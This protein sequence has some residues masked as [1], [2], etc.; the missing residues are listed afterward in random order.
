MSGIAVLLDIPIRFDVGD[1]ETHAPT[2]DAV[3]RGTPTRLILDTG[4]TDHVLTVEL[5]RATGLAHEPGEPGIDHAG[6]TVDS[7][8]VGE[9]EVA[10]DG[11]GFE[12]HDVVAITGPAPFAGWGIGGFLSPQHLHPTA[13]VMIDLV[14]NRLAVVDP[15]VRDSN[16]EAWLRSTWPDHVLLCLVR[17]PI[18]LTP[19][20]T[21]AIEPFAPVPAILNTGGSGTEFAEAAVPGLLG[22]HLGDTD[23]G[24]SGEPV[25]GTT[26]ENRILR[27]GEAQCSVPRL[28]IRDEIHSTQGLIGMDVLRGTVLLVAADPRQPVRWLVPRELAR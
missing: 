2:V 3:V 27:V 16:L 23:H 9:V 21:A 10:I 28:L 24:V 14:G 20:V 22:I 26:V 1:G 17:D 25:M 19:V 18:E 6:A 15:D 4:S 11:I 12:L 8:L 5:V 13:Q 7:W